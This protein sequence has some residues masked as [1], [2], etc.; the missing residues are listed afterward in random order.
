MKLKK[1]HKKCQIFISILKTLILTML[2]YFDIINE[3]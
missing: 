1:K 2:I 3:H